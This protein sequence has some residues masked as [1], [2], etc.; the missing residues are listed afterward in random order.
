[1]LARLLL[2]VVMI[3]LFVVIGTSELHWYSV[4]D[5][6]GQ[7]VQTPS[8]DR[9][10]VPLTKEETPMEVSGTI[11]E[12]VTLSTAIGGV[13]PHH[14]VASSMLADFFSLL[15]RRDA[16]PAT[17][18]L[19]APNHFEAGEATIQTTPV[20][21]DTA[22]GMVEP[23]P[24]FLHD[25]KEGGAEIR[26][27]TFIEEHGIYNVLPY[28]AHFLPGVKVVP[29]VFR[30]SMTTHEREQ[31]I[32]SILP[33]IRTSEVFVVSSIDFSHYLPRA[34]AEKKD[35]ETLTVLQDFD[36]SEIA[37]YGSDHLDSP[38]A[39]LALLRIGQELRATN[40]TALRHGNSADTIRGR[41]SS[42]TS[43]FTLILSLDKI[44]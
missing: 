24:E 3:G 39:M 12:T 31:F 9:L 25:V 1:M 10:R 17:I 41:N 19:L 36:L 40:L 38:G 37:R 16:R 44:E 13:V 29:V 32:T 22:F 14:L 15:S 5:E 33:R 28:I 18:L 35:R 43:H 7:D 6:E 21:W 23:D 34:E 4:R 20:V 11:S 27:E 8:S 42:T 26:P 2:L 30:Y